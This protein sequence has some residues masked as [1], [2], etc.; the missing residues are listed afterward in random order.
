MIPLRSVFWK[1]LDEPGLDFCSLAKDERNWQV[2]GTLITVANNEPI[3][4]DYSVTCDNQWVVREA[5]ISLSKKEGSPKTNK[6]VVDLSK[7]WWIQ[8]REKGELRD[9]LD[10]DI[11]LTPSTNTL[12]IRR[13][14]LAK[15]ASKEIVVAWFKFPEFSLERTVQKYTRVDDTQYKY[16]SGGFSAEISVDDMGL[17]TSYGNIWSRL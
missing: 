7:R 11:A 5:D 17:V 13:L 1:R 12:A 2:K 10:L 6:I 14:N 9:C 3:K 15:G 16:E 8:G 4:V